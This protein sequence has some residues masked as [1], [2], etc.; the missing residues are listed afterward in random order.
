[1][2][3]GSSGPLHHILG[4]EQLSFGAYVSLE[5]K[6]EHLRG[7]FIP[8]LGRRGRK[9]NFFQEK[10]GNPLEKQTAAPLQNPG[11][12]LPVSTIGLFLQPQLLTFKEL[13]SCD[14]KI[15]HFSLAVILEIPKTPQFQVSPE[16]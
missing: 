14:S 15:L 12:P 6:N 11:V 4:T 5:L 7:K 16:V 3:P 10:A 8:A 1:M 13:Y 9:A 2:T